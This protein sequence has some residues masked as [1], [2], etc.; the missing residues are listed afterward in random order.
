MGGGEDWRYK[1][2]LIGGNMVLGVEEFGR[3]FLEREGRE[4]SGFEECGEDN[5]G[6][7]KIRKGNK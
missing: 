3:A 2:V 5:K 6:E 1:R 4:G 7:E